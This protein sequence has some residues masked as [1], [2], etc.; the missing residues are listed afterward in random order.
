MAVEMKGVLAI[1]QSG[2]P[3]AVINASLAAIITEAQQ[4]SCFS[5]IY[6]LVHG[7]EGALQEQ[8]IDL[9]KI[10]KQMLQNLAHTPAS[11]LGS[12]RYRVRDEDY[13]QLINIFRTYD[14]RYFAQ[15]GGN[16]SMFV[17]HKLAQTAEMMGYELHVIGVP[18]TMDNDL[19]GTDYCPGYGSAARFIALAT[20]DVGRD[21]EAMATYEDVI[22]LETAG[23]DAGWIP[24]SSALLKE[25]EDDAP[26]LVYVPE[27]AFDE[28]Q[29]LEDVRRVHSRLGRVFVVIGEGIRKANGE[30]I[31]AKGAQTDS[32]GRVVY[33]LS[34]G[35]GMALADLIRQHLGL[36]ARV[37]RPGLIGR[38]LT[39]CISEVDRQAAA[40]VGTEAVRQLANGLS[41]YMVTLEGA[42]AGRI[43]LA[44]VSGQLKLLP[45]EYMNNAGNMITVAFTDYAKPLIG[46]IQPL[47]RLQGVPV[48]KRLSNLRC[49]I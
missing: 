45:R 24:A 47:V 28:T 49:K 26:H 48:T 37:L 20:R 43:T 31:A 12:S 29:F 13:E 32:L 38:A 10:D 9:T 25:N 15:V 2:G 4:Q 36:Q 17:A 42:A 19:V 11:A 33:S 7:I 1:A 46:D 41:D 27:I 18:K 14:I 44:E 8:F 34:P 39:S 16:G 30:F 6:G 3:T 21:L 22:I 40:L 5:G 35:A 23:R